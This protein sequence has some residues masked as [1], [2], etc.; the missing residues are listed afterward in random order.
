MWPA[1][2]SVLE[3]LEDG[4]P[5]LLLVE[6]GNEPPVMAECWQDWMWKTG[7]ERELRSRLR[8]LAVRAVSHGRAR[9]HLDAI[10]MLHVGPRSVHLAPKEQSLAALLV[11][12]FDCVVAREDLV[13]AGWPEGIRS[14]NVLA[15]RIAVLRSRIA[16]LGLDIRVVNSAG[17]AMQAKVS[18]VRALSHDRGFE[19]ELDARRWLDA[20]PR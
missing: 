16:P 3:D 15:S 19:D 7:T 1:E 8:Q 4:A 17:Y 10:G 11:D 2:H 13:R 20:A 18:R 9:P 6:E 5:R 14:Q 12:N